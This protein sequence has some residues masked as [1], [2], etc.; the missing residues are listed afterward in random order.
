M[1]E[2]GGDA[3]R[4]N[5]RQCSKTWQTVL[6]IIFISA[7]PALLIPG[8][9]IKARYEKY[10]DDFLRMYYFDFITQIRRYYFSKILISLL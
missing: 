9:I 6:F 7:C 1:A 2:N 5:N 8:A 10:R 3:D 4:G